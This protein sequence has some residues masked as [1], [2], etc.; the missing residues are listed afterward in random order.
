MWYETFC[1]IYKDERI[2]KFECIHAFKEFQKRQYLPEK[3]IYKI[4]RK[5]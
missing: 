4:R 5:R 2:L 3:C 1:N